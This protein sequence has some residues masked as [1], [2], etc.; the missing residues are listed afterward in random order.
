[1][2]GI[3]R[4][5]KKETEARRAPSAP[6][7]LRNAPPARVAPRRLRTAPL[8]S[9]PLSAGQSAARPG[10]A[11]LPS[12]PVTPGPA[13]RCPPPAGSGG[14]AQRAPAAQRIPR[15]TVRLQ[16]GRS[17]WAPPFCN[18]ERPVRA[19]PTLGGDGAGCGGRGPPGAE[20]GAHLPERGSRRGR[21]LSRHLGRGARNRL[22]APPG[23]PRGR[24][25]ARP[26]AGET[27]GGR[28]AAGAA[29]AVCG[30]GR[31]GRRRGGGGGAGFGP[32]GGGVRGRGAGGA[33]CR[34]YGR[35]RPAQNLPWP[36]WRPRKSGSDARLS[37]AYGTHCPAGG[38]GAAA[39]GGGRTGA[40]AFPQ[41]EPPSPPR[42]ARTDRRAER[43]GAPP[44][45][46][47]NG[48]RA[49]GGGVGEAGALARRTD[50]AGGGGG[51]IYPGPA[52]RRRALRMGPE[53]E[54]APPGYPSADSRDYIPP[55][56][57]G[58]APAEPRAHVTARH[59]RDLGADR[60]PSRAAPEGASGFPA[61]RV[62]APRPRQRRSPGRD[63]SSEAERGGLRAGRGSPGQP[64]AS[65]CGTGATRA[66]GGRAR[67][68]ARP[69]PSA[70]LSVPSAARPEAAEREAGRGGG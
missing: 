37:L 48:R 14:S 25:G 39:R 40:A 7:A 3:K 45:R 63:G 60:A 64:E 19:G 27:K 28:E 9:P 54:V 29:G 10:A 69:A 58:H 8:R 26:A 21:A 24:S 17:S 49:G 61:S 66:E 12:P 52:R 38:D 41:D 30:N 11:P 15:R 47:G 50:G 34:Q 4:G 55:W 36:R 70:A 33:P 59:A 42:G 56:A 35:V 13:A 57:G 68:A 53:R 51:G 23:S 43:S 32:R 2:G 44:D 22:E 67:P 5:E 16:R 62:A 6:T 46:F 20:R 65:G 31:Y 18:S 1:M